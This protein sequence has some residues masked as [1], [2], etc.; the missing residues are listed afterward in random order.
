M[1]KRTYKPKVSQDQIRKAWNFGSLYSATRGVSPH[2]T[3]EELQAIAKVD[4]AQ[5]AEFKCT[6]GKPGQPVRTQPDEEYL[7]LLKMADEMGWHTPHTEHF[8]PQDWIMYWRAMQTYEQRLESGD[9][10]VKPRAPYY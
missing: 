3:L 5:D 2:N 7:R 1:S 9:L 4:A 10:P 8:D 6:W